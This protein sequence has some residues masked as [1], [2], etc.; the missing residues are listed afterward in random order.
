MVWFK[1][2]RNDRPNELKYLVVFN[3][4]RFI[5]V[6]FGFCWKQC[7]WA[8]YEMN[9]WIVWLCFFCVIIKFFFNRNIIFSNNFIQPQIKNKFSCANFSRQKYS[10]C[11]QT[12]SSIE[13]NVA[14]HS[15]MICS[16]IVY[17]CILSEMMRCV[18]NKKSHCKCVFN[19][20]I[21]YQVNRQWQNPFIVDFHL[22]L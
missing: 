10:S 2:C 4:K 15:Q 21:M 22:T 1:C 18:G 19:E 7:T 6:Y 3:E 12:V 17:L 5:C 8:E 20:N 14:E 16:I 13:Q 11:C 9:L